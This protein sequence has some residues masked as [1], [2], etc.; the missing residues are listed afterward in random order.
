LAEEDFGELFL[1]AAA[2]SG[3]AEETPEEEEEDEEEHT[4]KYA[5]RPFKRS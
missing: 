3:K 2:D 4:E 1:L 5:P